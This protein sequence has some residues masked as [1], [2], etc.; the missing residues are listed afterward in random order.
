MHTCPPAMGR[1]FAAGCT[2]G[3]GAFN[4]EQ[5]TCLMC[6]VQSNLSYPGALGLGGA[7]SQNTI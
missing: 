6:V 7:I 5:G 4:F 3:H 2:D 1:S